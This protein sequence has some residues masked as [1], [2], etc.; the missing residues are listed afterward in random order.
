M[1]ST[2]SPKTTLLLGSV[3]GDRYPRTRAH[4]RRITLLIANLTD[5]TVKKG[6]VVPKICLE[7]ELLDTD[8]IVVEGE[9]AW[10]NGMASYVA[11]EYPDASVEHVDETRTE[12]YVP[13]RR[14]GILTTSPWTDIL[15]S[16]SVVLV[17]AYL[18][19][20]LFQQ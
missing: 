15:A 7:E 9:K 16:L 8:R 18:L 5:K 11:K 20:Y 4:Q 2:K 6:G 10:T 17:C 12:I 14:E 19:Y 13:I 3:S 1:T